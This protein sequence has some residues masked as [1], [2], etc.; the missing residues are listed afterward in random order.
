MTETQNKYIIDLNSVILKR[1]FAALVGLEYW[2]VQALLNEE[3]Y[4]MLVAESKYNKH[5]WKLNTK[6]LRIIARETNLLDKL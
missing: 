2:E 5:S 1:D 6:Q 3:L 4:E